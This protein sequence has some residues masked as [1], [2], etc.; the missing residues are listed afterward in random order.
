MKTELLKPDDIVGSSANQAGNKYGMGLE[1]L[2]DLFL[3]GHSIDL[4]SM[5]FSN[6]RGCHQEIQYQF[7]GEIKC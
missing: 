2:N 6:V 1:E 7:N 4:D 5:D 3:S